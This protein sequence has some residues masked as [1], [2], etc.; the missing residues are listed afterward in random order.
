[1]VFAVSRERKTDSLRLYV[2]VAGAFSFM[3]SGRRE[4]AKMEK[5]K[6]DEAARMEAERGE[7][8]RERESREF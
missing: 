1:M 6:T 2:D 5:V 8:G 4:G 7:R 3:V